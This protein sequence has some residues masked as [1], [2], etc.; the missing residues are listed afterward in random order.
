MVSNHQVV[1]GQTSRS[2]SVS[3]WLI[4]I[5]DTSGFHWEILFHKKLIH[6]QSQSIQFLQ[7]LCNLIYN[8]CEPNIFLKIINKFRL[9]NLSK[10]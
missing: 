7:F 5:S 3:D 8:L 4:L 6:H 2:I 9:T 1:E 10:R